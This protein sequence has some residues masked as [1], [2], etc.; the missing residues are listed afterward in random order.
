MSFAVKIKIS[1]SLVTL[2]FHL[3]LRHL[4]SLKTIT[5]PTKINRDSNTIIDNIFTN[6][7]HP[8]MKSGNFTVGISD[9]LAS[10]LIIPR[11][12]QNHAPNKQNF[13]HRSMK[14]FDKANFNDKMNMLLDKHMPLKRFHKKSLSVN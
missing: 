2:R 7:I 10:F 3:I 14:N 1:I 9:H 12:N 13:F 8:D 4:T 11:K 5:L 6:N